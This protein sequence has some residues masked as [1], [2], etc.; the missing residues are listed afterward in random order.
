MKILHMICDHLYNPWFGGGG[1]VRTHEI[2][3][4]MAKRHDITVLTGN[5]PGAVKQEIINGVKYIRLGIGNNVWSSIIS[6]NFNIFVYRDF[7]GFDLVVKDPVPVSPVFTLFL[8]SNIPVVATFHQLDYNFYRT[9]KLAGIL[10]WIN[11][12]ITM[13]SYKNCIATAPIMCQILKEKSAKDAKITLIP[14]G[15]E[16]MLFKA[17]PSEENYILYLGRYDIVMKGLDILLQAFKIAS[18]RFPQ[19][20]LVF[21]GGGKDE[22]RL[23]KMVHDLSLIR[24]VKFIGRVGGEEKRDLMSKCL[25]VCMPS[26]FEGWGIVAV[27]AGAVGKP[28]LGTKVHGLSESIKDGETGILV[29]PERPDLLAE[30]MIYLIENENERKRLGHNGRIWA[31]NFK[32]DEVA[33]KQEEF[34]CEVVAGAENF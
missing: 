13:R 16:D 18:M 15:V 3:R 2:Y 9:Y 27:E 21:A 25:L 14:Y 10:P 30:K 8:P 19:L 11:H 17:I 12:E 7:G 24:K 5:Y 26:R 33:I 31:D 29:P 23:K 34:Y 1:P 6:Y 22:R 32:W 4:R 28:I 20:M